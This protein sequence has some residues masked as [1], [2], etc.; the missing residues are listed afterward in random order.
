VVYLCSRGVIL[1]T[2]V[3]NHSIYM[4]SQWAI[5]NATEAIEI[6][7][8]EGLSIPVRALFNISQSQINIQNN[9][10]MIADVNSTLTDY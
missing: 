1:N 3:C 6:I 9:R 7:R 2:L 5:L 10:G 8:K 4:G